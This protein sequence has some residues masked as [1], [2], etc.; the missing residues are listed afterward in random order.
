MIKMKINTDR[1]SVC[2][3]CN[4]AYHNT[5]EMYDMLLCGKKVTLCKKCLDD[6]FQKTLKASCAYNAKLKSQEDMQRIQNHNKL[7]GGSYETDN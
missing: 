2:K 6:I 5:P 1:S 3:E 4:T 7:K